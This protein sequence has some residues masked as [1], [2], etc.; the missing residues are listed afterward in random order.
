MDGSSR[1]K[2]VGQLHV[3]QESGHAVKVF[4]EEPCHVCQ[5]LQVVSRAPVDVFRFASVTART[6]LDKG[7]L[8]IEFLRFFMEHVIYVPRLSATCA[9]YIHGSFLQ[10]SD[11]DWK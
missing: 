4:P 5:G 11:C 8:A 7:A 1:F 3:F 10:V 2:S 9:Y 6:P